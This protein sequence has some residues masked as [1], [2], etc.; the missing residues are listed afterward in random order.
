MCPLG[1]IDGVKHEGNASN[2]NVEEGHGDGQAKVGEVAHVVGA[3]TLPNPKAVVVESLH[4]QTAVLAVV[5]IGRHMHVTHR[6]GDRLLAVVLR[7]AHH[8]T[9]ISKGDEQEV[10]DVFNQRAVRI[11]R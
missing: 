7:F 8:I 6:A 9:R 2:E 10:H 4:A 3:N 5:R 11:N 1:R